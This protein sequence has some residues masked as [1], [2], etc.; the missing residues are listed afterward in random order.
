MIEN[1]VLNRIEFLLQ[2]RRWSVYKLAQA[3]GLP[4]SSLNN[5][6]NR[7]TCPTI[8]TLEKICFGLNISLSDFFDYSSNPLRTDGLTDHE[9]SI[10]NCYQSLSVHD[11]ELFDTYLQ[12]LCKKNPL[13]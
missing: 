4:Y 10:I 2:Y 3:S 5:I 6:F 12:G 11:K 9:Q 13:K 1:E 7:K 8:P